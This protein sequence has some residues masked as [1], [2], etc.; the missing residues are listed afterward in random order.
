MAETIARLRNAWQGEDVYVVASG[1]TAG[2]LPPDHFARYHAIGVNDVWRRFSALDLIVRKESTGAEAT[3]AAIHAMSGM[4]VL[5]EYN[6]GAYRMGK[7]PPVADIV[8][9]HPDNCLEDIDLSPVGAENGDTLVVS[10]STITSAIHLAAWMGAAVI[11]LV[12]HDCGKL[13]GET[14]FPGYPT[15]ILGQDFYERFLCKIEAQTVKLRAA[16]WDVYG[17]RIYSINPFV[18]VGL[19][20]HRYERL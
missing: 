4:L 5:S 17:C 18:N 11:Y 13:D 10:Y 7:N 19:E 6:C 14:N 8:F 2:F 15:A 20:G 9:R 3:A 16:L 12:G 1:P